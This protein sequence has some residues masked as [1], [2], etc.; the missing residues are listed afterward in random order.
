MTDSFELNGKKFVRDGD[1][2]NE[3]DALKAYQEKLKTAFKVGGKISG[4]QNYNK[5][6]AKEGQ[7]D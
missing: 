7:K 5:V 3:E 1:S 4:L 2:F 6:K